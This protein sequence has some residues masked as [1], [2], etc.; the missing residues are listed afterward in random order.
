MTHDQGF[1]W[2]CRWA[3]HNLPLIALTFV[4]GFAVIC[5]LGYFAEQVEI[6]NAVQRGV[7]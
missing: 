2:G 6:A 4:L 5:A 3:L 7:Q 1:A